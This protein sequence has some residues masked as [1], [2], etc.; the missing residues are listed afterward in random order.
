[1]QKPTYEE[2]KDPQGYVDYVEYDMA[3]QQYEDAKYEHNGMLVPA[4][5]SQITCWDKSITNP[6]PK[7]DILEEM[8]KMLEI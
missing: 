6:Q 4:L 7:C 8:F 2:F 1:M 5:H 3:L